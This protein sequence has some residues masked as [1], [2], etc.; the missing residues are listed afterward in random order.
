[1]RREKSAGTSVE[2]L[3]VISIESKILF[4]P[5]ARS[6][7]KLNVFWGEHALIEV[8]TARVLIICSVGL[9][10][11][12]VDPVV[13]REGVLIVLSSFSSASINQRLIKNHT[14]QSISNFEGANMRNLQ[15]KV[16]PG[17]HLVG[18]AGACVFNLIPAIVFCGNTAS[19]HGNFEIIDLDFGN[20]SVDVMH[21]KWSDS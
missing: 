16:L 21:W 3:Q 5:P 17:A 11:F 8:E 20:D 19:E 4:E 2:I 6:F 12:I 10:D 13:A 1:M 7:G 14:R 9:V 15:A 18:V